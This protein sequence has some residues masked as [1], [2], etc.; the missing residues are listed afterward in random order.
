[1]RGG[2]QQGRDGERGNGRQAGGATGG[3]EAGDA[4][5]MTVSPELCAA[6]SWVNAPLA[7]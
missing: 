7:T 1:M 6:F 5:V 3:D 4:C 2:G